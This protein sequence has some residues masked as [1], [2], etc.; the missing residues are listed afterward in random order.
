M[1]EGEQRVLLVPDGLAGERVDQRQ[2]GGPGVA[3]HHLDT[4]VGQ[5]REQPVG[6]VHA[7]GAIVSPAS[8]SCS[9]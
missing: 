8:R 9:Q 7:S 1:S 2:L 4:L 6:A 5:P 3:E